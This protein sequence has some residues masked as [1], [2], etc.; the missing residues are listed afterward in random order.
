M[1]NS[2]KTI[3][4]FAKCDRT[5]SPQLQQQ[6]PEINQDTNNDAS[7]SSNEGREN[8]L[9][10]QQGRPSAREQ[11]DEPFIEVKGSRNA[12][13]NVWE[14]LEELERAVSASNV[15]R[16]REAAHQAAALARL[17]ASLQNLAV[18]VQTLG[19]GQHVVK[20]GGEEDLSRKG[21]GAKANGHNGGALADSTNEA[22]VRGPLHDDINLTAGATKALAR[23]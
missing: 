17:D 15:A 7:L 11:D 22:S 3:L 18:L 20:D 4:I 9:Q 13:A 6:Q 14:K 23:G 1:Q 10:G 21:L 5:A 2:A 12:D 8:P 19:G 16:E